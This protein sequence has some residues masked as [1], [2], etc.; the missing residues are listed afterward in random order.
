MAA[1]RNRAGG[2]ARFADLLRDRPA[3]RGA[4]DRLAE[5]GS[6]RVEEEPEV[7]PLEIMAGETPG[8]F[9]ASQDQARVLEAIEAAVSQKDYRPFLLHGVTGSGKTEV[10]FRAAERCLALG[11]GALL[12]VPE[13]ALTPLL[14]REIGRARVGKEC[15]ITC[16]SRWSPYH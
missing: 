10:Y 12:L 2:R 7:P 4:L 11:R 1:V 3:L 14:L 9:A 5:I 6:V 8:P 16:R 15:W 13:I